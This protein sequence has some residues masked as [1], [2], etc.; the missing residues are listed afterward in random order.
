MRNQLI[1]WISQSAQ[2][3]DNLVFLTGDLGFGV[4]EDLRSQMGDRFIN[5]GVAEA[6][7]M[8][9]AGG[10]AATG[11]LPFAYSI[12]PFITLR[13]FEQLRNDLCYHRHA[14]R[15]IGLGGGFAYGVLGPSHHAM[16]DAH[17]LSSLPNMKIVNAGTVSEL[18][19][20]YDLSEDDEDVIYFRL[21]AGDGADVDVGAITFDAPASIIKQGSDVNLI[22]TGPIL[23]EVLDAAQALEKQ[24]I[25]AQVISVPLIHPFPEEQVAGLLA[26]APVVAIFEGYEKNPLANGVMS[27]L[28]QKGHAKAFRSLHV[29]KR[30]PKQSGGRDFLLQ[31]FNLH[32]TGIKDAVQDLL[33]A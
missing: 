9:V 26:E 27:T 8:S 19:A 17:V 24:G 33:R 29:P 4:L 20:L 28:L 7:L 12:A 23:V 25:R 16:E 1:S 15:I 3:N 18:K 32:A 10:L 13:C 5:A 22:T 14:A 11:H 6:N 2:T 30:F 31:H 21:G